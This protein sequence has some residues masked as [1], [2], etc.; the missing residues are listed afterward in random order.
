MI[1]HH[2]LTISLLTVKKK[3]TNKFFK[4]S[5]KSYMDDNVEVI[6]VRGRVF[7]S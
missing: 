7:I 2:N 5:L 4:I 1:T 3:E 6:L